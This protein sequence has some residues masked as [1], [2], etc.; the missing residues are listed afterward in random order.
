M[1]MM[2]WGKEKQVVWEERVEKFPEKMVGS[3]DGKAGS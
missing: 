3:F 2:L 1:K